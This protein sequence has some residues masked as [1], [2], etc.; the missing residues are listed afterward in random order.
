MTALCSLSITINLL[1]YLIRELKLGGLAVD[2][3]WAGVVVV[4]GVINKVLTF[5]A[6]WRRRRQEEAG[7]DLA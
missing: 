1:V 7:I 4:H 5:W 6:C 3:A 2:D